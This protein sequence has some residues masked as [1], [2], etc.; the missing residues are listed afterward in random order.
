MAFIRSG[1]FRVLLALVLLLA[2]GTGAGA[3]FVYATFLRDLPDLRSV[4]DYQ[5]ALTSRVLDYN[6]KLIGSY[7]TERRELVPLGSLPDHVGLAFVAAED[8]HF[9]EHS[10]IDY[11]SILRAAWVDI[12]AGGIKQGASTITMQLV[13]QM[14]LSP[15][16]LFSRK[17]REMVLARKIESHF[18][19]DEILYLY[20]NQI[21]FGAGAWGIGEAAQTYFAKPA[22]ELTVSE[23]ALLAGLPQRPSAYSPFV[24]PDLAERRRLYV[25]GRMR[26]DEIISEELYAQELASPPVLAARE[27]NQNVAAAKHFTEEV[28][29]YLFERLGGDQVLEG[30]L[31]IETTLDIELQKVAVE[32]VRRGLE[33]HDRRRGYRGP[34]RQFP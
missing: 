5:P 7:A 27:S 11:M 32:A 34:V 8:S 28:R 31:V 15:E 9:F 12:R 21:Y 2:F 20:L 3:A 17:L 26:D 30:G 6:G 25:L 33:D 29:R 23:S 13:K 1:G 18:T 16:R 19:K 22:S 24:N 10:G 4:E 14:L